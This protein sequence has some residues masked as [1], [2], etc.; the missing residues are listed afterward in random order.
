MSF[1]EFESPSFPEMAAQ[2]GADADLRHA[3]RS[4]K[5]RD[6]ATI[7][8]HATRSPNGAPLTP[9]STVPAVSAELFAQPLLITGAMLMN[10]KLIEQSRWGNRAADSFLQAHYLRLV[11]DI[12]ETGGNRTPILVRPVAD[13]KGLLQRYE[14][15]CGHR[16][17][18]AC[19]DLGLHVLACVQALTDT[20]AA[21][22]IAADNRNR[23]TLAPIEEGKFFKRLLEDKLYPSARRMA[24]DLNVDAGDAS[25]KIFLASLPK[26][27]L[28]AVQDPLRLTCG[29]AKALSAL[30]EAD[31]E[32]VA[33]RAKQLRK[34]NGPLKPAE[35]IAA[36][37]T[38]EPIAGVGI[39][40]TPGTKAR[41]LFAGGKRVG[42]WTGEADGHLSIRLEVQLD[43][44]RQARVLRGIE[45]AMST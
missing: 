36:L 45:A 14:L 18:R 35:L 42:T 10:P 17:L 15:V 39:S 22:C 25:R 34:D 31:L 7:A 40:N 6:H 44:V 32:S 11:R 43:Q 30:V 28:A 12:R 26:S 13:D 20:A 3:A 4:R 1:E 2:P 9:T 16:R 27:I 8:E 29:H 21:A 5:L 23:R 19:L 38:S 24:L 37:Q 33:V 41:P